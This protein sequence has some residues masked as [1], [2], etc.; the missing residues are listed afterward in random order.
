VTLKEVSNPASFGVAEV[1]GAGEVVR[2]VEKPSNPDSNLA[3]V[4]IYFFRSSSVPG[5]G[6]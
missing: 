1:N 3:L 5:A 6:P 4:G 2:L